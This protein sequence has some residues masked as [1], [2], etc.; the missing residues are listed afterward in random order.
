MADPFPS[1]STC[2]LSAHQTHREAVPPV[3]ARGTA[4]APLVST[5]SPPLAAEAWL[6]SSLLTTYGKPL[7]EKVTGCLQVGRCKQPVSIQPPQGRWPLP[8]EKLLSFCSWLFLPGPFI[9]TA[10]TCPLPHAAITTQEFSVARGLGCVS[11]L[12]RSLGGSSA[13][14]ALC[15]PTFASA[16]WPPRSGDQGTL[17]SQT[18]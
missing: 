15:L 4:F 1:W 5:A 14:V 7:L 16:A 12:S 18:A 6:A 17:V 2:F 9:F 8:L 3:V 10:A 11:V 13:F